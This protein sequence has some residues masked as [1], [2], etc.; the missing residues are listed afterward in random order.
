MAA[1]GFDLMLGDGHHSERCWGNRMVMQGKDI[2]PAQQLCAG[3]PYYGRNRTVGNW[4]ITQLSPTR[5][6][7]PTR[8]KCK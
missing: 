7:Q 2:L 8:T 6:D 3:L 1:L 5:L 4:M